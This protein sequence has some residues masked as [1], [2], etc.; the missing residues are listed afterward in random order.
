MALVACPTASIG[1]IEHHDTHLGIDAF[2]ELIAENVYFCGFHR[3]SRA[4][5]R[6]AI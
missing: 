6:G 2:P 5:A 3:P 4:S 1:T